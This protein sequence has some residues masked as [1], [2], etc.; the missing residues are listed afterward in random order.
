LVKYI[1]KR[2]KIVQITVQM[3]GGKNQNRVKENKKF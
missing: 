1:R 2:I 3:E